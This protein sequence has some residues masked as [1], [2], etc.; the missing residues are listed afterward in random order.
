M[1]VNL[2]SASYSAQS[3]IAN[4]QRCINLYP[5]ANPPDA[6]APTTFYHTPGSVVWTTI[7]GSYGM[8]CLFKASNGVLY[9]V[10]GNKIHKYSSSVWTELATLSTNTGV[11]SAADNGVYAVF[12]DGSTT[13]PAIKLSDD[14]VTAMSGA[15]WYG[16]DFVKYLDGYLIFNRPGT[17]IFY[18]TGSL[19]LSLDVLDFASAEAFPDLLVAM[20]VDHR[21]LWLFGDETT[22]VFGNSGNADFP[23]E[24]INGSIIQMGC[25]AKHSVAK[26]DNSI[27]WLGKNE[28]GGGI[29]WRAQGY[30]PVR[31]STHAIENEFRTYSTIADAQAFVYQ[32]NG[33]TFYVLTFPTASKTWVFDAASGLWHERAYRTA[34]NA[35]ERHRANCHV[36]YDNM[37]LVGDYE[38]G[39][40]YELDLDTYTDDGDVIY[41][42]KGFQHFVTDGK[43]Q[44]FTS[45]ELDMQT[46]VGNVDDADPQVSLRWSDNGGHTWSATVLASIA[47]GAAGEYGLKVKRNKLGSGRDRVFEVFTTAKT[48][49]VLQGAFVN[50]IPGT[51]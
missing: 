39:D 28:N 34:L 49:V 51:A 4:A 40:I 11:V 38:T 15:G 25:A 14:S 2:L 35:L 10:R 18:I 37:H 1:R 7:T 12:T 33:H 13:A 43:R 46:G 3:L 48:A 23:F 8:R 5:E 29:V 19:D 6:P 30:T 16:S 44:F 27:V 24:R 17:Q 21:E 41:R 26:F 50:V 20:E 32:Q 31:L 22:E 36:F 42:A 47:L 45:L 9:G